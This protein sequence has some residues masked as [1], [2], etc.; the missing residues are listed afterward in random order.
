MMHNILPFLAD[1]DPDDLLAAQ[2]QFM[3]S[4]L[5]EM[6][7]M[8]GAVVLAVIIGATWAVLYSKKRKRRPHRH[9]QKEQ[10][11][12]ISKTTAKVAES[13][14]EIKVRKKWRRQRRPHRPLNPTLAQT[15]GL[16]PMR[17]ENNMPPPMP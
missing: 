7:A 2:K 13:E 10:P 12:Y 15:R 17:D 8:F 9:H 1:M 6:V 5:F 11:G 3:G 14:D 16:P 4:K